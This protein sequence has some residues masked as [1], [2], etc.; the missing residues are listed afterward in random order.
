MKRIHQKRRSSSQWLVF[1]VFLLTCSAHQE[2][3]GQA[4]PVCTLEGPPLARVQS[5]S[6]LLEFFKSSAGSL[7]SFRQA[8][9]IAIVQVDRLPNDLSSLPAER[10]DLFLRLVLPSAVHVNEAVA[11]DRARLLALEGSPPATQE[12]TL[13]LADLGDRYGLSAPS[14]PE[15]L[16]RVDRIP[17][18]LLLAQ[19]ADES[20]W[21]RSRFSI[22]GNALYGQHASG[23]GGPSIAAKS[24]PV[25]M[26]AFETICDAT[27]AYVLN[28]NSSRAYAG[29]R[30]LRA[31]RR[32]EGKAVSGHELAGELLRYS[33]R[34]EAYVRD[35]RSIIRH[36]GL[37]DFN[38]LSGTEPRGWV[39]V[40]RP[41]T[42]AAP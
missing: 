4:P 25:H 14:V 32:R 22:E 39:Q 17:I 10:V 18:G 15:L 7:D 24:A 41:P 13:F 11:A 28:L 33:E 27:R 37:D 1:T 8:R 30:S 19:A 12:D 26:A 29:L 2:A 9:E 31:Q 5:A 36:H 34:G 3:D 20:G 35:L 21:G 38:Q 23:K 40:V 16:E 42:S 6:A